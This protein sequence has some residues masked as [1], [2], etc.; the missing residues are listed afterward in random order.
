VKALETAFRRPVYSVQS[1]TL[2]SSTILRD[3][4]KPAPIEKQESTDNET[5]DDALESDEEIVHEKWKPAIQAITAET[6]SALNASPPFN[7]SSPAEFQAYWRKIF[8]KMRDRVI[9]DATIP[10]YLTSPPVK[11][12]RITL[13]SRQHQLGCPCC[14]P[15]VDPSIVLENETGVTKADLISG[16]NNTLYG[17]TLPRVYLEPEPLY[18]TSAADEAKRPCIHDG[19]FRDDSGVVVFS[20]NWMTA[21]N[22]GNGAARMYGDK[23]SI[24]LYCCPPDQYALNKEKEHDAFNRADEP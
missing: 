21:G 12:F 23:A 20:Y 24:I 11:S 15:D 16:I 2:V 14:H 19:D 22:V 4:L 8:G 9:G 10:H 6:A 17:D 7:A 3:G 5:Q 18:W 13:Y 1:R